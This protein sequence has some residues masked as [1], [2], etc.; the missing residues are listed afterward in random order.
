MGDQINV[1]ALGAAIG[2]ALAPHLS[3]RQK[4][5]LPAGYTIS[6][7]RPHGV[8]GIFGAQG[9]DRDIF[10]TRVVP[11]G[12]LEYLPAVPSNDT[13]PIVG[14]LTGFTA[15]GN[16]DEQETPC[17]DPPTPGQMKS[18]FQGS[19]FGR[20]ARA[21]EVMDLSAAGGRANRG[22]FLDLRL[23][24]DPLLSNPE[25]LVPS[26]IPK[27]AQPALASEILSKLYALGVEFEDV[28]SHMVWT[29]TPA[30]NVGTGY[31][32]FLGL[33][34]LVKTG[35]TDVLTGASCPSLDSLIMDFNYQKVEDNAATLFYYLTTMW[36][37]VN[38]NAR[39]MNMM[40]VQWA[41]VMT[42]SL[43][44][45]VTDLWPCVYAS[46][47]CNATT[48]DLS[49][50]V[51]ALTMRLMSDEQYNGKYLQIDGVRVPVIIDDSMPVQYNKDNAQ[52]DNP[53]MASDIYLLPFVVKGGVRV[54]YAE[55][56][57]FNAPNAAMSEL[58]Q[59][60]GS[61]SGFMWS[62]GGKFLWTPR[63]E[64]WCF[65]W[66]AVIR[67]RLRLLTPHLAA[68]LENVATCPLVMPRQPF[69]ADPYFV[70]HGNE[71]GNWAQYSVGDLYL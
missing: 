13:N 42:E 4:H 47:R 51:D 31:A 20:I 23:V 61:N 59:M 48:N 9:I 12:L 49:N 65:S 52:V 35:H 39:G 25:L 57:D 40:P 69:A 43:F 15:G 14:Y 26:S 21:T 16:G 63:Q 30:N 22:E 37:V 54:L 6:T 50:S 70:D 5:N 64:L 27:S 46:F 45:T 18:C 34:S 17:D 58:G 60:G 41:F 3:E 32:E 56:Y 36:R 53:C 38:K 55:Y 33:E 11:T 71:S 67:P 8:G 1:E 44:R 2:A 62:D 66:N 7:N 68:R 19:A 24:N 10:S 29:G 28:L